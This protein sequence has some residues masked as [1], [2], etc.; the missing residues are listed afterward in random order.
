METTTLKKDNHELLYI[1]AT[2]YGDFSPGYVAGDYKVTLKG[3]YRKKRT[4]P[5]FILPQVETSSFI[6]RDGQ[7]KTLEE[8]LLNDDSSN[9]A[10]IVGV[11]GIGGIGKS[12]LACH[13]AETHRDK[14]PD[15]VIGIRLDSKKDIDTIA[16][17]F[18][19]IEG[20]YIDEADTRSASAIMQD[21]FASKRILLI[22]D[23][24][25]T[26]DIRMLN[27]GGTLCSIIVTT[28][29][30][31][32]PEYIN[33]SDDHLIDLPALESSEALSL[34]AQY[35]DQAILEKEK[36]SIDEILNLVGNLPLAVEIVAKTIASRYK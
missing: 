16:K 1:T 14:F 5:P 31:A 32:L 34:L 22:F 4:E 26:A 7:L 28:R 19:R 27:P 15:G 20:E 11:T 13:F 2:T 6:G 24:A 35:I 10:A 17:E 33:V 21:L 9:I 25:D 3:G 29:D 30:R 12:A 18:A 36:I 8:A 23:N